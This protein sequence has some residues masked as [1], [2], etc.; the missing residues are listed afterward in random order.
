MIGELLSKLLL[1]D[2]LIAYNY[3]HLALE[4][5]HFLVHGDLIL[6]RLIPK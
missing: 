2:L 6:L 5:V 1:D 4:L 3:A